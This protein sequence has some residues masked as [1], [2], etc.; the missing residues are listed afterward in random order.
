[1]KLQHESQKKK[2]TKI[3]KQEK[4]KKKEKTFI[5]SS[6]QYCKCYVNYHDPVL[7][8]SIA[9]LINFYLTDKYTCIRTDGRL[10]TQ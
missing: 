1:M 4:I 7:K 5:S 10:K 6:V 8:Q 3:Q 9:S 2:T